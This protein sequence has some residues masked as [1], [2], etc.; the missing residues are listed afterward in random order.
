MAGLRVS[1]PSHGISVPLSR[2]PV[3][4]E[5]AVSQLYLEGIEFF[6]IFVA[7]YNLDEFVSDFYT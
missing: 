6:G 7:F 1:A 5:A 2:I 4:I 3:L